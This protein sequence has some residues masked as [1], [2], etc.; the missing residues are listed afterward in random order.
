MPLVKVILC[1]L[2]YAV[3]WVVAFR[4]GVDRAADDILDMIREDFPETWSVF[5][6]EAPLVIRG[7]EKRRD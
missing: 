1:L 3:G 7:W 6:N 2:L 4:M 5:T